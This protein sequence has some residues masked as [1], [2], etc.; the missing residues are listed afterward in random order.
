MTGKAAFATSLA[1]LAIG[2]SAYLLAPRPAVTCDS[3][4]DADCEQALGVARPLLDIYLGP[5]SEVWVHPGSCISSWPC[6]MLAAPDH[7]HI[8]VEVI[9]KHM[10]SDTRFVTPIVLID[11]QRENWTAR[12]W[13]AIRT[14]SGGHSED[15]DG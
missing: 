5:A 1:I 10:D 3:L 15:C 13:V 11:R 2:A 12:C 4:P 8:T 9:S 7:G 6:P 14:A